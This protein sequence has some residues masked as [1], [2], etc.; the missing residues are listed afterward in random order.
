MCGA[1]LKNGKYILAEGGDGSGMTRTIPMD[2]ALKDVLVVW[3]MNG[4]MLRPE[5]GYP[6]RL[7]VPGVQA[8]RTNHQHY[9][10]GIS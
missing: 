1:D 7:L 2:A 4:E 9:I 8:R 5:N 3:G 6:L 10:T